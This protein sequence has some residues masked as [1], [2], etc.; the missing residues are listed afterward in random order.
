M[1]PL[2]PLYVIGGLLGFIIFVALLRSIRIVSTKTAY[3]VERLGKYSKN[4]EAGFHLLVPFVDKVRYKHN[5]KEQAVDVPAQDCFTQD[6]V[7]VRVDGVLYLQVVDPK[8]ASY[9]IKDYKYATIQLAQTT[10]RSVIGKLELDRTFEER[11]KI[12][13]EVVKSVDEA[14]DPW[15]V[16]VSRY[17]I[18][19][20]SVPDAILQAMEVQ[21]KAEREKRASISRSIGEME[22]RIN[23]SQ[24][25]MEEAINASEGEKEKWV[26][27]AE[28]RASE[29]LALAKATATGIRKVAEAIQEAGGEDAVAM[30]VA[31]GYIEE[32]KSLARSDTKLVLPMDMSNIEAVMDTVKGMLE[33]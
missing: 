30:R 6:N 18:Q 2:L 4:L 32:L 24:A 15:G 29:I 1:N 23:Y 21:M 28:G 22:S 5:L 13:G 14:S 12:N 31:E 10:M 9:G 20:I 33:S 26:N 3:I 19:N 11:Q 25:T 8:R 17:E 7:K 27:E 16:N